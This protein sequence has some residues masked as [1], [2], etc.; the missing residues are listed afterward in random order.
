M[1]T[2]AAPSYLARKNSLGRKTKD[3]PSLLHYKLSTVHSMGGI[4]LF[5]LAVVPLS[6][7]E[8]SWSLALGVLRRLMSVK[9]PGGL[10][11]VYEHSRGSRYVML[12]LGRRGG[13]P[14][15]VG[16]PVGM[17]MPVGGKG[18]LTVGRGTLTV[19][20]RT[21]RGM[22]MVGSDGRFVMLLLGRRGGAPVPVGLPVG[23]GM[24]VGGKGMLTVGRGTL[25][26]VDRIGRGMLMVGSGGSTR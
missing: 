18:M 10:Y 22:L 5:T 4:F 26:V 1:Y 15:P 21:G 14:V 3:R 24:P 17:G 11:G 7:L 9:E 2:F 20:D 6:R 23:M 25:T 16:L 19:V 8:P 13:A 12:L